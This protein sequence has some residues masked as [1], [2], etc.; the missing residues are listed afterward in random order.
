MKEYFS[1]ID[2]ELFNWAK[3]REYIIS[4]K[5]RDDEVRLITI[6]ANNNQRKIMISIEKI[7]NFF[8]QVLIYE[9]KLRKKSLT[10]RKGKIIKLLNKAEK[11]AL[12][13]LAKE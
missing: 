10:G 11:V 1:S 4:T 5:Y 13:W 9:N 2:N 8:V 6:Y 12:G 7:T 3:R